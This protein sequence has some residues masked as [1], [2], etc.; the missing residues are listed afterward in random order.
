MKMRRARRRP[1]VAKL[2]GFKGPDVATALGSK[3]QRKL[4]A[5]VSAIEND[6]I[7]F[8]LDMKTKDLMAYQKMILRNHGYSVPD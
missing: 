2:S 3:G 6:E 5:D 7:E 8:L 1:N 4:P